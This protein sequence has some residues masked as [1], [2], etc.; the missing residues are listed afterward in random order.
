MNSYQETI[1][2][3]YI[4][5]NPI[6]L[7]TTKPEF[8][9]NQNVKELFDIAKEHALRYKE[10]PSKE[11]MLQLIKIKGLGEKFTDDMITGLYNTKQLLGEYDNEW[12]ENN[13]GPWIQVRNLDN[14]LRKVIAYM[15]MTKVTA[16]NANEVVER[17][18]HML[19]SETVIDFTF[20]LGANF[21]DATS[22]LQTRLARTTSGYEFID[23]CTK[24]GYWKGSLIV[25]LGA[26]KSGKCVEKNT[27]ITIKNKIT[28]EIKKINIKEFYESQRVARKS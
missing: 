4:L 18:R 10:P 22:H 19:S 14:V 16:E 11:Q 24:G 23:L 25:L 26:P 12:L 28:G 20:N 27:Y 7:N 15:K 13:A 8:F 17:V 21:W 9:T 3:H 6:F 5:S 1:F 2:F